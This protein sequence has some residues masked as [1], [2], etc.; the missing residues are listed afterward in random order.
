MR[1]FEKPRISDYVRITIG[2]LDQMK[3]LLH[4]IKAILKEEEAWNG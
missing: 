4:E 1:H 2:T 3:A